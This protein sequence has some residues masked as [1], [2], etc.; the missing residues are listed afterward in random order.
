MIISPQEYKKSAWNIPNSIGN[1]L[2]KTL[3]AEFSTDRAG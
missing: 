3:K 1:K 2:L